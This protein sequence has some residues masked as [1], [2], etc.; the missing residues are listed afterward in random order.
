MKKFKTIIFLGISVFGLAQRPAPGP[1]Q[2]NPI[3]IT[4]ATIHTGAGSVLQNAKTEI[5]KNITVLNFFIF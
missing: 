1:A 5:P 3:A 4:N 2:K